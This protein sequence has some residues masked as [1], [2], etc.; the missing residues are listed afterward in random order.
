MTGRGSKHQQA[1]PA[2]LVRQ[3]GGMDEQ[4]DPLTRRIIGCAI[5]LHRFLGPGLLESVYRTGLA[6]EM[7]HERL[8]YERERPLAVTYRGK[9]LG[10]Y[11]PDFIVQGQ[12]VVEVKSA[13]AHDRVFDAQ[14]LTYLRLTGLKTGLLLNFGRPVLKD[15]IKRFVL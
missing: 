6:I 3:N 8:P 9:T 15:G 1:A 4:L 11:R 13:S 12:V 2:R 14:V 10:E 5:E 7:A